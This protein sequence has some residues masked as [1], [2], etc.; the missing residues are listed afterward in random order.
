MKPHFTRRAAEFGRP[1]AIVVGTHCQAFSCMEIS[2]EINPYL[3]GASR[4]R[5]SEA[6]K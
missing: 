4:R 2:N 5:K 3:F 6:Q 1:S